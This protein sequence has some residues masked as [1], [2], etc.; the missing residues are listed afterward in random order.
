MKDLNLKCV[1]KC[2]TRLQ[3]EDFGDGLLSI[4][5]TE[6]RKKQGIGV[7]LD[8]K[9]IKKVKEFLCQLITKS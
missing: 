1:C 2:S 8:E 9:E 6:R 3:L 4:A 7:I 5:V